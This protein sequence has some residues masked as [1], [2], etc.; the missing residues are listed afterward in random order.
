VKFHSLQNFLE[1]DTLGRKGKG[2]ER[3]GFF[4]IHFAKIA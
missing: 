1:H 3:W 4:P 2:E